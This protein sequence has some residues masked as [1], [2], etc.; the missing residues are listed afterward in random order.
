MNTLTQAQERV[1]TFGI[2]IRPLFS[3]K[4][5]GTGPIVLTDSTFS[6]GIKPKTGYA[7][8]MVIRKGLTKSLSLE[9]GLNYTARNFELSA[10]NGQTT[11]ADN[12]QIVGYELPITQL[13]FIRL[14]ERIYMNAAAGVCINMFP[15]DVYKDNPQFLAYA[16]RERILTPSLIANLGFEYRSDKKG[17]FYLGASLNRPFSPIY[18]YSADYLDKKNVLNSVLGSINGSYLSVDFKYFFHEDPEKK[19][20]KK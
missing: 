14:S 7:V 13:V 17:Y 1:T 16:G 5:F 3:S 10:S 15:S 9:F 8:G 2:Q 18:G 4:F 19:G 12:M 20:K 11:T 6:Y